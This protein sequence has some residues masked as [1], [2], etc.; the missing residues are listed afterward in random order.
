MPLLAELV[1][2]YYNGIYKDLAPTELVIGPPNEGL[3]QPQKRSSTNVSVA[4]K[5]GYVLWFEASNGCIQI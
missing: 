4:S 5:V 2:V 1:A 3:I